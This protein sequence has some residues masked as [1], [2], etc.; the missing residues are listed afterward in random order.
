V[1]DEGQ[2]DVEDEDGA[3]GLLNDGQ[4]FRKHPIILF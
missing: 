4:H 2:E 3:D 1:V